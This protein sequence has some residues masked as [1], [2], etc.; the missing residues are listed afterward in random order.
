VQGAKAGVAERHAGQ[1]FAEHDRQPPAL[2]RGQQRPGDA[3]QRDERQGRE[4]HAAQCVGSAVI[5][6]PV[7]ADGFR[8]VGIGGGASRATCPACR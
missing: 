1:Q 3:D 6:R 5:A 4:V 8:F 2:R 7:S